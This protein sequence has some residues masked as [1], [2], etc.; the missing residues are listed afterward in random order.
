MADRDLLHVKLS[1]S[2]R[3]LELLLWFAN[4]ILVHL[5]K[6]GQCIGNYNCCS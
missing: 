4:H 3:L 2:N 5:I 6:L 1:F